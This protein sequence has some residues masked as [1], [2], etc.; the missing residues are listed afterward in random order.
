M[1][2][3]I[4][5]LNFTEQGI[6]T[7]KQLPARL[8]AGRKAATKYGCKIVSYHMTFGPYDAVVVVDGKDEESVAAFVLATAGVGNIGSTTMRAFNETEIKS[9]VAKLP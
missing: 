4:G 9:I 5:L 6:K 3:Y 7:V 1:A 2:T 8:T